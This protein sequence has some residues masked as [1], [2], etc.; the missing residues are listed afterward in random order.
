MFE[1]EY[2]MTSVLSNNNHQFETN[3]QRLCAHSTALT[4]TISF[5]LEHWKKKPNTQTHSIWFNSPVY[6]FKCHWTKFCF[7]N[8]RDA[9]VVFNYWC[10][11]LYNMNR[12]K[13]LLMLLMPISSA[14]SLFITFL[15]LLFRFRFR[16][17]CAYI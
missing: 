8:K 14:T 2:Y 17:F 10:E 11:R 5:Y 16:F 12:M 6:L 4:I 13:P 15:D 9:S 3:K 1:R 7:P